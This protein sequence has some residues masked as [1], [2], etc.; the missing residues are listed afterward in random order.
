M[1][2]ASYTSRDDLS[3][4]EN[5]SLIP[6]VRSGKPV[7]RSCIVAFRPCYANK[8]SIG[9]GG[10]TGQISGPRDIPVPPSVN[11]RRAMFLYCSLVTDWPCAFRSANSDSGHLPAPRFAGHVFERSALVR[12]QA[13]FSKV[14]P[15]TR[16]RARLI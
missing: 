4:A 10:L 14:Y 2:S 6:A 7:S 9:S 13:L 5:A 12:G 3:S 8:G 1:R 11:H 16:P 15:R